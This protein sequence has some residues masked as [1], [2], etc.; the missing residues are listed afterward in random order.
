MITERFEV[1]SRLKTTGIVL[2]LIGVLALSGGFAGLLTGNEHDKA[3]FWAVLLQNSVFFLFI[4]TASIFIQAAA[5]LAQGGWIVS[6]P[7]CSRVYWR[8]CSVFGAIA[9]AVLFTI[10]FGLEHNPIYHWVHPEGD[11]IL[12]GKSAF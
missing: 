10:V 7:P 5:G 1:P 8:Q 4:S 3:R 2:L 9:L 12:E 6:L 11:K